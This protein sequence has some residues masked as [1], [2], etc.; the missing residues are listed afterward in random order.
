MSYLAFETAPGEALNEVA[1]LCRHAARGAGGKFSASTVPSIGAVERWLTTSYYWVRGLLAAHGYAADQT[2]P[3]VL[4]ILQELN[5][6]DTCVKVELS[7]PEESGSGAPNQRFQTFLDR[8]KDLVEMIESGALATLGAALS[9]EGTSLRRAPVAT[10]QFYSRKR[11]AES[12]SDRTQ[13]RIRRGMFE[14]P[15]S[16]AR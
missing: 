1:A 4:A 10:G 11:L 3:A 7:L 13:H 14:P 8:R 2:E 5:A 12:D 16:P 6:I 9:P 15:W